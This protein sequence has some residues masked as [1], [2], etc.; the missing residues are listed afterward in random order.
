MVRFILIL[1]LLFSATA[2]AQ[3]ARIATWNLG[4]FFAIPVDKLDRI[5]EGL[6][7][8][9]ADLVILPELNPIR[10]GETIAA[11]L[12]EAPGACF[13]AAV[14]DQPRAPQEIGLVFKCSVT[15]TNAGLLAGSD[16]RRQGYR[17]AAIADVR[18]GEFDFVVVGLHLKAGRGL[19]DRA[20]RSEQAAFISGFVQGVLRSGENDVLIIGDYNMIPGEDD[21]N[22]DIM[23]A[24]GSLRFV[25]S[26][27]LADSFTHISGGTP[28]SL[29]DGYAFTNVDPAEYRDGSVAIVA[30][31]ERLGLSLA[32]YAAQVTDHL[33]VLA[34]FDVSVDHD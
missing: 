12:S 29:L 27:A 31:H 4:G 2:A 34:E 16:L 18:I 22:F 5:V 11:R 14:P 6:Q 10:H 33:P 20:R 25:S 1:S 7:L 23:N 28:G 8:L 32:Q 15:V 26:E 9:N 21:K 17:N 3:T 13:R 24:D 19:D 30:M